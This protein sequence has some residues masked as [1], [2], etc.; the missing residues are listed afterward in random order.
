[1]LPKAKSVAAIYSATDADSVLQGIIASKE[2][3]SIGIKCTQYPVNDVESLKTTLEKI[4]E[5]DTDVI[6]MPVDKFLSTQIETL[7]TFSYENKIPIICGDEATLELGAFA[8]SEVNYR[9]IGNRAAGMVNDILFG[10]KSPATLSVMYKHDCNNIVNKAVMD[11]LG[12]KIPAKSLETV[13]IRKFPDP[14]PTEEEET[15]AE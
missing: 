12:I 14:E 3:E 4:K 7:K 13:E 2:A 9:S 1:M 10:G 11:K 6:Y 15:Q 5:E 8:T